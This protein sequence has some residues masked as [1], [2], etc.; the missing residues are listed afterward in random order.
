MRPTLS[1]RPAVARRGA[2]GSYQEFFIFLVK[3]LLQ[4][5]GKL[6]VRT[7]SIIRRQPFTWRFGVD[8][9]IISGATGASRDLAF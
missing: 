9:G 4:L 5:F 8:I 7:Q 3:L 2:G 6:H 1:L